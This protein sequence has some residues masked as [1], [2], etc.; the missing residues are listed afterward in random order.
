MTKIVSHQNDLSLLTRMLLPLLRWFVKLLVKARTLPQPIDELNIRRDAPVLYILEAYG[1][2]SLLIL[3]RECELL[4]L[5]SPLKGMRFGSVQ[6]ARSY[7]AVRRYGGFFLQ[8]LIA[9]R[10]SEILKELVKEFDVDS[11]QDLQIVPVTVL[12]GRAP[13]KETNL[14]KVLFSENW[15]LASRLRRLLSILINGR[16]T[17]VQFGE[18]IS[19]AQ[20]AAEGVQGERLLRRMMRTLRTH[21]RRVRTAAIGPDRSHRRTLVA[22]IVESE[23]VSQAIEAQ[24]KREQ[25]DTA[26]AKKEAE[27][28]ALEVA[29]DY[30]YTVV[31]SLEIVLSW[32]WNRIYRGVD[33][34]HFNQFQRVAPSHEVI[35]VPCHRSHIDY[36][37][38]SFLLYQR[39]FVPPHIA[40]GINL[41][42][43]VVGPLLRRGGAFFLRRTFRSQPLYAAVFSEYVGTLLDKGVHIEYFI[44]G[45]RSRTGRLLPPRLGMLAMTV[46]AY[47][48]EPHRPVMFQP[49]YIGYER[50][51]ES[52]AYTKELKGQAKKKE[53]IWD[54]F[55]VFSI[56]RRNYGQ[57]HVSFGEPLFLDDKL[58]EH[59]AQWREEI[60]EKSKPNWVSGLVDDLGQQIMVNIN[61]SVAVNPVN[62]LT[63]ALMATRMRAMDEA[64][65]RD[66]LGLYHRLIPKLEYGDHVTTT[67]MPAEEQIQY[68]LDLKVLERR[69][70]PLGDVIRLVPRKVVRLTYFRN[71]TAHLFALPSLLASCFLNTA[72]VRWSRLREMTRAIYPFLQNELFLPW[73]AEELDAVVDHHVRVLVDQGLLRETEDGTALV[74]AAGGSQRAFQLRILA[75]SLLQT[76]ERYYITFA[77]LDKYGSG[78]LSRGELEKL[79]TQTAERISMLLEYET[80][81]FFDRT[82][83]R[84][85]IDSLQAGGWLS[86]DQEN[87]LVFDERLGQFATD[88]KL[89][90]SKEVRHSILQMTSRAAHQ[91]DEIALIEVATPTVPAIK[92]TTPVREEV[93]K[94]EADADSSMPNAGV[95]TQANG[96]HDDRVSQDATHSKKVS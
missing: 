82:L 41:N 43:P 23:S 94:Q 33:V 32:F 5:P 81:E 67:D 26:E 45:T 39:G 46:R 50:L 53:S 13:D 83:F 89:I 55:S 38:L 57:V 7:G 96:E 36:L 71:N 59:N 78:Q 77:V 95:D 87:R 72:L 51:V 12:I 17:F 8:R 88:A 15:E 19:M 61:R 30:S 85:F 44:E 86:K 6:T 58:A 27:K 69:E 42:L 1:L 54:L 76:L 31:R 9:R 25:V 68:G 64:D 16:A 22:N 37:L 56:L 35:Y 73:P 66:V 29:A 65:L 10:S 14:T 93:V 24:A 62:L 28:Y 34:H 11:A 3:E 90:L 84:Q 52:N 79:C 74:R 2:A 21:F 70:H 60:K 47:L 40:A 63:T 92:A 20:V 91:D 18:P 49:V 48:Q 80:P 75:R 4:G